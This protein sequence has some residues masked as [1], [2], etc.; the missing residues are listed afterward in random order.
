MK[1]LAFIFFFFFF[2]DEPGGQIS[3]DRSLRVRSR[4]NVCNTSPV[5]DENDVGL[6]QGQ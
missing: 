1:V 3:W 5:E 6:Y 2:Y 4:Q